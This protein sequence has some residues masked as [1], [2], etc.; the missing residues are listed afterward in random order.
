M[1]TATDGL[2]AALVHTICC[3][4]KCTTSPR[5]VAK[6]AQ[7]T[8]AASEPRT[9]HRLLIDYRAGSLRIGGPCIRGSVPRG[10]ESRRLSHG[11]ALQQ[12]G[13]SALGTPRRGSAVRQLMRRALPA[14][15]P[16]IDVPAGR[17]LTEKSPRALS[18]DALK[19]LEEI[20]CAAD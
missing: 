8:S 2:G 10:G 1:R 7:S 16:V 15:R 13:S 5:Y 6:R 19:A 3:V 18:D 11:S 12:A 14:Q 4:V 17:R 9:E 20:G